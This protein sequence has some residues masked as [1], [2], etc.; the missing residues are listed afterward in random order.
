MLSLRYSQGETGPVKRRTFITLLGAASAWPLATRAQQPAMPMVGYL[1]SLGQSISAR[2]DSRFRRGL[3]DL[4]FVEGQNISVEYRWITD[5]YDALPAMAADLVRRQVAVIFAV[6]PPAVLAAKAASPASPIIFVT[7]ADPLKFGFVAS[8]NKPGGNITG[9]WM[10][11]T[12]LTEKRLQLMHDLLPKAKLIGLLV[13]PS[14]PVAEPQIREAQAVAGALGV[15]LTVLSAVNE[16]DFDQVFISLAQQR[17]DALFVSADPFFASKREHLVALAAEH[18]MPATYEFRE[19]V[20]AG[21]LMSYGT[22]LSDGFYKGGHYVG[23]ILKGVRPADLPV[24]QVEKYELVINLK[25]AK[26]LGLTVPD[27]FLG[28]ADEAIE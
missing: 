1:S 23:E 27:R 9:I 3:A 5:S 11:L 6:G 21:G 17:A 12:T 4:G 15:R 16:N 13:N 2:L 26:A 24:E 8:F 18:R 10:V 22:V 19:F 7:G 25:T 28:I 14:S 20:E